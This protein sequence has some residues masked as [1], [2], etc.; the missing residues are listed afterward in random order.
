MVMIPVSI[1]L[2][3]VTHP[4]EFADYYPHPDIPSFQWILFLQTKTLQCP[5]KT[6]SSFAFLQMVLVDGIP[7]SS[8][9]VSHL[10][11]IFPDDISTREQF[12]FLVYCYLV[13]AI[14]HSH[15][16]RK[17]C[18][19]KV[20]GCTLWDVMHNVWS[21]GHS[22]GVGNCSGERVVCPRVTCCHCEAWSWSTACTWHQPGM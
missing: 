14:F 1:R 3:Q 18:M 22:A 8:C 16:D 13:K 19:S 12:A 6:S 17:G 20:S 21:T 4:L 10:C 7:L 15:C 9:T 11:D 2:L 5:A